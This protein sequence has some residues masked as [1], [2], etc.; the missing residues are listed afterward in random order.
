MAKT[1]EKNCIMRSHDDFVPYSKAQLINEMQMIAYDWSELFEEPTR[2]GEAMHEKCEAECDIPYESGREALKMKGREIVAIDTSPMD[3]VADNEDGQPLC[4]HDFIASDVEYADGKI[5]QG[6]AVDKLIKAKYLYDIGYE[7]DE[8]KEVNV[9]TLFDCKDCPVQH[10]F[11]RMECYFMNR[12][13][14]GKGW[15]F[16]FDMRTIRFNTN[17]KFKEHLQLHIRK[18]DIVKTKCVINGQKVSGIYIADNTD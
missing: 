18:G 11:N 4:M 12:R 7:D 6:T 17:C 15:F 1:S 5:K 8:Y 3:I 9:M 16:P 2:H 14:T 13:K 10:H